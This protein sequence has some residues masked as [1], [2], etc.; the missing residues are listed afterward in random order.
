MYTI[1]KYYR[2]AILISNSLVLKIPEIAYIVNK[3][4]YVKTGKQVNTPKREWL[5]YQNLA[6][7]K[8]RFN[9]DIYIRYLENGEEALLTKERMQNSPLTRRTLL[10]FGDKF[11]ELV[12]AYPCEETYIRGCLYDID[13]D[14]IMEAKPG[15]ILAYNK[16]LLETN[17]YSLIRELQDYIYNFLARWHVKEYT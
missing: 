2:N 12:T 3:G 10:K 17:E 4:I 16:D 15:T 5:Y 13:L 6:G 7:I 14:T 9:K 1:D 8:T 11:K